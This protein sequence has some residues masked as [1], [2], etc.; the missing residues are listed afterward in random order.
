V[1]TFTDRVSHMVSVTGPYGRIPVFLEVLRNL[2]HVF[3]TGNIMLSFICPEHFGSFD[4]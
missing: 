4:L 2:E 3:S 1:L